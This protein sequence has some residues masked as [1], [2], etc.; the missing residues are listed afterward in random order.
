MK[1]SETTTI[2]YSEGNPIPDYFQLDRATI[3]ME[4]NHIG[5]ATLHL[6]AGETEEQPFEFSDEDTFKHGNRIKI[7]VIKEEQTTLLFE[8]F[9]LS[10]E[11]QSGFES[12]DMLVVECRHFAYL[13]TMGRKNGLFEESKDS[14][15]FKKILSAYSDI[16]LKTEDTPVTHPSLVQY[17]C[18]DWDFILARADACGMIVNTI[19]KDIHIRKPDVAS[20]AVA[21]YTYRVDVLNF[22]GSLSSSS[23]YSEVNAVAWSYSRQELLQERAEEPPINEQGDLRMSDLS[24]LNTNKLLLQTDASP[25]K[26]SLKTWANAMALKSALARYKGSFT[27][28]GNGAIIPGTTVSL[29][30]FGK[31][32]DGNAWVGRVEH[33]IKARSWETKIGMG[34]SEYTVVEQPDITAPLA[35]GLLPGIRGL[36][37]GIVRKLYEDPA[38][39]ER[40]QV[41]LPLLNGDKNTVWARLATPYSGNKT[42]IL[43]VPEVGEEVVVGFFNNDPCNPVILGCLFGSKTAPPVSLSEKNEIK[44]ILTKGQ[45]KLEFNDEKKIITIRTP[46]GALIEMDD[47]KKSITLNDPNKNSIVLDSNGITLQSDKDINLKAKGN[48]NME[49]GAKASVKAKSDLSLEGMNLN[50]KAQVGL[51]MKGTATAE[52]SASGNTIVKGAMVM[53]N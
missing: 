41:E 50:G 45:L 1:E 2:L 30:G 51:T 34:L 4:A 28:E 46:G 33:S 10:T 14:D 40:I 43:F 15:I 16:I 36:H 42:G 11:L 38:K 23:Q 53:I 35:S 26:N 44:T 12:R 8:G 9:V 17:Y 52:L 13:T 37:V 5:K 22:E 48:I 7:E 6:L 3:R 25:E 29:K 49:A 21:E 31:R 18:T 19:G 20:K 24:K 32:F 39:E 27:V 47:D